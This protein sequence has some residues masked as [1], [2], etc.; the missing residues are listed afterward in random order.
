LAGQ[1]AETLNGHF[2]S[3]TSQLGFAIR[4]VTVLHGFPKWDA[5]VLPMSTKEETV[6]QYHIP[7][8]EEEITQ[9]I[10]AL[11]VGIVK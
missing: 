4:S 3:R 11:Q 1:T 2:C 8:V 6:N 5:V 7:A 10:Q 9:T